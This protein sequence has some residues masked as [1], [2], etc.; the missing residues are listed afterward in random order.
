MPKSFWLN[1]T[2]SCNNKCSWCYEKNNSITNQYMPIDLADKI[3]SS[4][5]E[6]GADDCIIIGGEPTLH[7]DL[8][9]IISKVKAAKLRAILVTNG[10]VLSDENFV[11]NL[12]KYEIDAV[13]VSIHGWDQESYQLHTE[14]KN[15]FEQMAKSIL[16]LN[17]YK[18]NI[19]TTLVLTKYLVPELERAI[20]SIAKIG[21]KFLEFNIGAPAVSENEIDGSYVIPM[22][23]Q[24]NA[25]M[26][27]YNLCK[28]YGIEPGFNLTIPH[29]LF[30]Q[31]E[32][33]EL[34]ENSRVSSGCSMR[35]GSGIVFKVDGSITTCNHFLD[36][37]A[38]DADDVKS[39][40]E[41]SELLSLWN[42]E[43]L[44]EIRED[45]SCYNSEACAEC[46]HW[47]ACGGG[48]PINWMYFDPKKIALRSMTMENIKN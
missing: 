13:N 41:S 37:C 12:C 11:K 31:K 47:V 8:L 48:C 19:G 9:E 20:K 24:S 30:S 35:N 23:E 39:A 28:E 36:F 25:V 18:I 17:K 15:G 10:R 38:V 1:I 16:F 3:V 45:I 26:Q 43:D 7:P 46:E 14:S 44:C 6:C 32:L 42:N 34:L 29:C 33:K 22:Q 2:D 5:R 40:I 4:M 21:V 27:A